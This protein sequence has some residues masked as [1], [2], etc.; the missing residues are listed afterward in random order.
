MNDGVFTSN[1]IAQYSDEELEEVEDEEAVECRNLHSRDFIDEDEIELNHYNYKSDYLHHNLDN[2]STHS[3][4]NW[5]SLLI[6]HKDLGDEFRDKISHRIEQQIKPPITDVGLVCLRDDTIEA[7]ERIHQLLIKLRT[8][9]CKNSNINY[10]IN[11]HDNSSHTYSQFSPPNPLLFNYQKS[12]VTLASDIVTAIRQNPEHIIIAMH[13]INNNSHNKKAMFQIAFTSIHRLLHP[14]SADN[15]MTTAILLTAINFQ[16]DELVSVQNVFCNNDS[17][18][19]ISRALFIHDP[20]MAVSW[21]PFTS[22]MPLMPQ[23]E[24]ETVLTSLLRMYAI[25]RYHCN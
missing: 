7:N 18:L 3:K 15:S 10:S 4:R 21:D 1:Y 16:L 5:E 6:A 22:P 19:I 14:F 24:D 17:K 20:E 8:S 2:L 9:L 25:R 23:V 11:Y 13:M 12:D